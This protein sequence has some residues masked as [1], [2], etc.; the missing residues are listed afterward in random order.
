[1]ACSS[2]QPTAVTFLLPA[3][4]WTLGAR[5][6]LLP[7]PHTLPRS[8]IQPHGFKYHLQADASQISNSSHSSK[9]QTHVQLPVWH[10][11][12]DTDILNSTRPKELFARPHVIHMA[13]CTIYLGVIFGSGPSLT[14]H[15][16]SQLVMWGPNH[17]QSSS[18]SP[19]LC[20][21]LHLLPS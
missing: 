8:S 4:N 10:L 17:V 21:Y 7:S 15:N 16:L 9:C 18:I 1:M 11:H 5:P 14:P 3:G 2:P 13:V 19:Y 6:L 20:W 12:L